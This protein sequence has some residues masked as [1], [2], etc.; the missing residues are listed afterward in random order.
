MPPLKGLALA[1]HL[2]EN[3][4]ARPRE[5]KKEGKNVIGY[6]C[7][8][9]PPE[10][11]HAA[12]VLPYRI[13]GK[14]GESTPEVDSYLEPFGCPYVR[15]IFSRYLRGKLDFLDGLVISHSCDMVQ[16]LYGIWTYY[17][18]FAYS[19]LVNVPHQ[20]H[21]WSQDFY[22]RELVFFKESLENHFGIE[23]TIEALTASIKL[24]NSIRELI[25]SLYRMRGG[26]NPKLL[27]SELMAVLVAGEV[28]PP[29]EF[30]QLLQEVAAEVAARSD[31]VVSPKSVRVLVWG[32][33]LDHPHFYRLIEAAGGQ[34]VADD[35]CL[36]E[37]FWNKDVPVTEDPFVGLK[38]HYLLN[39]QGPCIDRGA[40]TQRF[41]YLTEMARQYDVQGAIGYVMSFCDPHKFDYPDLRGYLEEEG[42]PMLLI[43]D[44]YSLQS[45][46]SI[47]TRLQAFIEMLSGKSAGTGD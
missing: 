5:L 32:S 34:V 7:C 9:A 23:I 15:N 17:F 43:D 41:A 10:I 28:L 35:T 27:S 8:F 33:I 45:S 22:Y 31:T 39:F 36:G 29:E 12:G 13:T 19:R 46:G 1:R 44:N 11:M 42:I 37:R 4:E 40:G 2:S 47:N 3:R 18:P 14:P 25:R 6:L 21:P 38:E 16:R 20:L 30:L 26:S 24:Y